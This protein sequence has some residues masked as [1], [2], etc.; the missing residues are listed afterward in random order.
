MTGRLRDDL[1]DATDFDEELLRLLIEDAE[2]LDAQFETITAAKEP[3]VEVVLVEERAPEQTVPDGRFRW[4]P[5]Y[6]GGDRAA[7]V[8]SPPGT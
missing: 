6:A 5:G 8:R 4:V 1:C 7:R 2:W 3:A